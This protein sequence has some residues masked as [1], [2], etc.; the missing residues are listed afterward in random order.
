M[1]YQGTSNDRMTVLRPSVAGVLL[2]FLA[3]GRPVMG[4]EAPGH[5]IDSPPN[6]I[7]VMADD[8]DERSLDD[9][10]AAGLVPN[11]ASLF[12]EQGLRFS[13]S[14]VTNPVCCPS[15]ATLWTGQYSHNNG[16]RSN[17]M[18]YP[19]AGGP[20]RAV[21][22]EHGPWRPDSDRGGLQL[23]GAVGLLKDANTLATRLQ[24]GGYLTAYVGKYLNGYGQHPELA[25]NWPAL[26]PAYIPPGWAEWHALIDPG[27]YCVYD[28][29]INHNGKQTSYDLPPGSDGDSELYQTHVLS[30]IAR[31]LVVN[32]HDDQRP[33]FLSVMPLAPHTE[34]CLDAYPD[35]GYPETGFEKRIRPAP[36]YAA[37]PMPAFA[38]GPGVFDDNADKPDWLAEKPALNAQNFLDIAAQYRGRLRS[39]LS[40]DRLIGDLVDA[41]G[42]P[43]MEN[44][45]LIFTS[46]NGW[47]YGEHRLSEKRVAYDEA[48]RVPLYVRHPATVANPGNRNA[49]VLNNDLA[50]TIL[51]FAEV[52]F[53]AG[54]FDGRS[55][56]PLVDSR[57]GSWTSRK[58]ALIADWALMP[59]DL[60]D[61]PPTYSALR[62]RNW[63]YI[64][65]TDETLLFGGGSLTGLE[66]YRL[67]ADPDQAESLIRYPDNEPL[68]VF[69][70]RL[71]L[72]KSCA[73]A[74]CFE[75]E[76]QE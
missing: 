12:V 45:I 50:P 25:A 4:G 37:T 19:V 70:N 20:P 17:Y 3:A 27:S 68:A 41:L 32:Y 71:E 11:I 53:A 31:D 16:V 60:T 74:S 9:L 76:N 59:E 7:L 66:L 51:E 65:T 57:Y 44:T 10:I 21:M 38:P 69:R 40:V 14:F 34:A 35:D 46:D 39:V 2:L 24:N 26:D 28:Y 1:Q 64:E 62:T 6:I 67:S 30:N 47:L 23:A 49:T 52:P 58:S 5:E 8:L 36:E 72:L 75:Y 54:D 15:R 22:T 55:F 48:A 42:E 56:A 18:F 61:H 63:L 33:L 73:G 29:A 43:V 13:Q